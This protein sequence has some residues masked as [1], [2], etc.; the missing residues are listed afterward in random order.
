MKLLSVNVGQIRQVPHGDQMV[1]TAIFKQPMEDAVEVGEL[2]VAGDKQA[3][4]RVH[5]GADKAVYVYCEP[6]YAWWREQHPELTLPPGTFGEN[7][8]FDGLADHEVSVG[9]RFRIGTVLVEV[10]Q[11][12]Q[13]C[14]KLGI[15]MQSPAFV[16]QFHQA[17]LPGFYLRVLEPGTL[18]AGQTIERVEQVTDSMTIPDIY[19]LLHDKSASPNQLQR[20]AI[21]PGLSEAWRHDFETRLQQA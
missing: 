20:A 19:R 9:D 18:Q 3:D 17:E 4:T 2:G 12:R 15:K 10:T 5:G 7:L 21:L 13:P 16:K 11:P 1:A 6:S 14:F 8:T